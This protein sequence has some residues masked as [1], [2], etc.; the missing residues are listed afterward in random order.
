MSDTTEGGSRSLERREESPKARRVLP[1]HDS[2]CAGDYEVLPPTKPDPV[3]NYFAGAMMPWPLD[4]E[5]NRIPEV[6]LFGE[7]SEQSLADSF[8]VPEAP[9][10][11]LSVKELWHYTDAAGAIGVVT[12]GE[13][14]ASGLRH[15]N[16][17]MELQYGRTLLAEHLE[18]ARLSAR[19]HPRQKRRIEGVVGL[20]LE[21]ANNTP[22]C[23]L[24]ASAAPDS[25]TQW[26]TYGGASPHAIRVDPHEPL[27]TCTPQPGGEREDESWRAVVYDR[28]AQELLL[29]KLLGFIAYATPAN[30]EPFDPASA[31][32][33]IQ[34]MSL[35]RGLIYMK[36]PEYA[37]EREA[38]MV[39]H[40]DDIAALSFRA[41]GYGVTAFLRVSGSAQ[42]WR[43]RKYPGALPLVGAAVGPIP[44]REDSALALRQMLGAH[45]YSKAGVFISASSYR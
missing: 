13:F 17:S 6:D 10:F 9:F 41:S 36:G 22:I 4:D 27:A 42:G 2:S 16:D 31:V 11:P 45:G 7:R 8:F 19:L 15:L 37:D 35:L 14:W 28:D 21:I 34:A 43:K 18:M 5:V 40:H 3:G 44:A 26:R 30:G 32:D 20:A 23:V 1:L 38:R 24:S 33:Q 39:F 25:L 12:N 29:R